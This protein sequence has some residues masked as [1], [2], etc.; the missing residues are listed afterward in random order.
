MIALEKLKGDE[1]TTRYHLVSQKILPL[2]AVT[3]VP[4]AA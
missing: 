1:K 3:G 2:G 4:G